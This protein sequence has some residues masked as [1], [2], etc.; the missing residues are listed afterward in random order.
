MN[1][2]LYFAN[3]LIEKKKYTEKESILI[4]I[5]LCQYMFKKSFSNKLDF[6]KFI[7]SICKEIIDIHP[8]YDDV[9]RMYNETYQQLPQKILYSS[10]ELILLF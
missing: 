7:A 9:K 6:N 5:R 1:E 2:I 4:I 10:Q 8:M 3:E